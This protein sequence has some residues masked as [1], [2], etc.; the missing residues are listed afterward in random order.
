M[1]KGEKQTYI[2][3]SAQA[4][5]SEKHSKKNGYDS[6]RGAP[7]IPFIKGLEKYCEERNAEL[8]VLSMKGMDASEDEIHPY[9]YNDQMDLLFPSERN[10]RL[11]S[12]II[13]SDMIVPP[14]NVD[15]T[16]GRE[17][18]VQNGQSVVYAH[19]KQRLK[20][21]PASNFKMPK[22]MATT[23]AC[24]LPNYNRATHRGDAAH[25]DHFLGALIVE[26]I[27]DTFY[28]L[29]NIMSQQN[30]KFVDMGL[31]YFGNQ[32]PKILPVEALV[33][34]DIHVGDTDPKARQ[35]NYEMI[36]FFKPKK[37]IIHDLF[38]GHSVNPH[39]REDKLRRA[40]A[41][42]AGRLDIEKEFKECY[43]EICE[44]AKAMKKHGDIYIDAS[45]HDRFINRYLERGIYMDEPWNAG[46]SAYLTGALLN[47]PETV[48]KNLQNPHYVDMKNPVEVGIRK[49]G[50]VPDNVHFLKLEDDLKVW[51]WQLA[52]HGDKGTSGA[53][54]SQRS[55]EISHGKG[56]FGHTHS[57]EILRNTY[58]VG[59]STYLNLPYTAGSGSK[60]LHA[61]GVLYQ[62]GLAQ[63][64]PVINGKWLK[65]D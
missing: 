6:R 54:G 64:I 37:L 57:P 49:M 48:K 12:N 25:G 19:S 18:F 31:A 28:N 53:K 23:G 59:T 30:G 51:G 65:K 42:Q 32:N 8:V 47:D 29:R 20:C 13:I 4:V 35:A 55:K 10:V 17:R 61:N 58:T 14:Q 50:K 22:I 45:N 46:I 43:A 60:W 34:G 39:E 41:Y 63:L 11:N 33:L 56:M 27:D 15:P 26:I 1:K 38:N 9:F 24:T 44:L 40:L 52:S 2:V 5:Q 62:G 3:T 21:V 16:A 7:H 36:S